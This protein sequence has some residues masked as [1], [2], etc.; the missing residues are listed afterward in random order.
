YTLGS[1][2][3]R[4]FA[5]D[6]PRCNRRAEVNRADL[7]RRYGEIRL[8]AV[9]QSIAGNGGCAL[10]LG[11]DPHQSS[12][13]ENVSINHLVLSVE[14]GSTGHAIL[15]LG[16]RSPESGHLSRRPPVLLPATLTA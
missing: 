12:V 16:L 9:A 7:L 8:Q 10:A 14:T 13:A 2:R 15:A 6:C 3:P 4:V 5:V 1:F 11:N